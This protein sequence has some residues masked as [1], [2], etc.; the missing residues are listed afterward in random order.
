MTEFKVESMSC[1]GCVKAVTRIIQSVDPAAT[2]DVDLASKRVSVD[3]SR[4]RDDFARALDE[5]G[6][7]PA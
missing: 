5:G 2:V 6:Y 7:P 3:S 1:G 4:T